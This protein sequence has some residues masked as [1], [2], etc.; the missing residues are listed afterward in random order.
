MKK[1]YSN[2]QMMVVK[3]QTQQMLAASV[4]A[5]ISGTQDNGAALGREADFDDEDF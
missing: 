3:I 4:E 5:T 2:P 1:T